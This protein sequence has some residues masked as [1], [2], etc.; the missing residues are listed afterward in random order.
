MKQQSNRS[1]ENISINRFGVPLTLMDGFNDALMGVGMS[2]SQDKMAVYD[3]DKVIEILMK[4]HE[5][6]HD[7][8][9]EYFDF[10]IIGAYIGK[11]T[12]VFIKRDTQ[13]EEKKK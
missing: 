11:E 8:A 6:T 12:P 5:M 7:E 10:N 4:E 9:V 3:Y 2:F 13:H 1:E